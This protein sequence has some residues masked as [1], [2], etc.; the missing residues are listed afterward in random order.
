MS[1][2]GASGEPKLA[3]ASVRARKVCVCLPAAALIAA[4]L[5]VSRASEAQEVA[6]PTIYEETGYWEAR[7]LA[8]RQLPPNAEIYEFWIVCK[9][10]FI[11]NPHTGRGC[12]DSLPRGVNPTVIIEIPRSVGKWGSTASAGEAESGTG[13]AGA[14][15]SG[16]AAGE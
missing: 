1:D 2:V 12:V 10:G 13:D 8:E 11:A 14:A 4:A 16:G 15:G 9:I 6:W 3:T 5:F 7:A